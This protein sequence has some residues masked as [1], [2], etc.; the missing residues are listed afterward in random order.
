MTKPLANPRRRPLADPFPDGTRLGALQVL[1]LTQNA[2]HASN[3]RW[4]VRYSCCG[5]EVERV[6][7]TLY[8][9]LD[10]PPSGCRRCATHGRRLVRVAAPPPA[11]DFAALAPAS[12][13]PRPPSLV[14]QAPGVWG[15]QP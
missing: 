7:A 15:V 1:F 5:L 11:R 6:Y 13:W 10:E 9:F 4:W 8:S 3:R 12:A 2:P 14:G